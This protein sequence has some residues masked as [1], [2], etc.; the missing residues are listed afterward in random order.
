MPVPTLDPADQALM[1]AAVAQ[2]EKSFSEGGL[3]I[4]AVLARGPR[5]L[6]AGHNRRVPQGD[7]TR[8]A[9]WTASR[10]RRAA[11]SRPDDVHDTEPVHDVRR[12]D[13]PVRHSPRHG[14][15]T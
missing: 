7:P 8:M 3:P 2:A 13:R 4:G 10:G 1:N 5:L 12:H 6:A 11:H 15:R 9:R 14:R